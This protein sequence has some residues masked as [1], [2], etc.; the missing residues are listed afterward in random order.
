MFYENDRRKMHWIQDNS[1]AMAEKKSEGQST[2]AS[3]FLMS[4]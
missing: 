4:E 3:E 2:M 1:K